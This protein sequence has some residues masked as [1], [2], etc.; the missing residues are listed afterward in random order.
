MTYFKVILATI[1][2]FGITGFLVS[3]FVIPKESMQKSG[4]I[5]DVKSNRPLTTPEYKTEV[6]ANGLS[7]VWDVAQAPSGELFFTERANKISTVVGGTARVIHQ[8]QDV[9]VN[10]EGGMLGMIL[11]PLF[12][13]N[14]YLYTC[15]NTASDIRVVRFMVAPDNLSLTQRADIITGMPANPSG[16]HSGCRLQF[17]PNQ[18]LWV[19]TGDSARSEHP[20]SLTSLGGKVLRVDRSGK[21]VAGNLTAPFDPRIYSYGHRNAQGLAFYKTPRGSVIGYS[22]EHGSDRDDEINVLE[23][24]NFGWDPGPGYDES[25]S[26]TDLQKFPNAIPAVWRSGKPTIAISGITILDGEK[27]GAREGNLLV[28]VQKNKHVRMLSFDQTGKKLVSE[29]ELFK[30]YRRIR[31]VVM[32]NDQALFIT[33]DNGKSTDKIIKITPQN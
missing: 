29:Q 12:E 20:Q 27:W 32:G 15:F 2:F 24:G 18:N 21:A 6:I 31:T 26:M 19:G 14:R 8:P 10:G 17:D 4:A 23:K 5:S 1:G 3:V 16:R 9:Y 25:V 28:A 7:N 33:T 13:Q 11:D 30:E 22:S